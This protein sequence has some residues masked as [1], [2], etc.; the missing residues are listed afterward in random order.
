MAYDEA[1]EMEDKLNQA[2]DAVT[3]QIRKAHITKV[4]R[5]YASV[6]MTTDRRNEDEDEDEDED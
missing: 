3:K 6:I 1:R 5:R 4:T 2:I